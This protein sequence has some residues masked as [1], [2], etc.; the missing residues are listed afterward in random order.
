MI[1]NFSQV[2]QIFLDLSS[3]IFSNII[4]ILITIG[5]IGGFFTFAFNIYGLRTKFLKIPAIRN[6]WWSL[7]NQKVLVRIKVKKRYTYFHPETDEIFASIKPM[8][9]ENFGKFVDPP[10]IGKNTFQFVAEKMTAPIKFTFLPDYDESEDFEEPEDFNDEEPSPSGIIVQCKV[11]G[12]Q[13]ILYRD[14]DNYSHLIDHI[15]EIYTKIQ[16]YHSLTPPSYSN[17]SIEA[18]LTEDFDEDWVYQNKIVNTSETKVRAGKK[19]L[20]I[21]SKKLSQARSLKEYI[22]QINN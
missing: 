4:A 6:I 9:N 16:E 1:E 7:K 11:L 18:S 8:I 15:D 13:T 10:N 20:S 2:G 19:I 5:S 22:L 17:Y 12:C 3:N 14:L 21:N